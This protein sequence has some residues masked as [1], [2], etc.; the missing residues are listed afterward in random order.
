MKNCFEKVGFK[1]KNR[2]HF[3]SDTIMSTNGTALRTLACV[4]RA[5]DPVRKAVPSVL[6]IVPIEECNLCLKILK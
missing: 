4:G 6:V 2:I 3:S 5:A 1:L